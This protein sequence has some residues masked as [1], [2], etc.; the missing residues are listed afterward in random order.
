[1]NYARFMNYARLLPWFG[2]LICLLLIP[3]SDMHAQPILEHGA[4][5]RLQLSWHVNDGALAKLLPYEWTANIAADGAAKDVNLR[6]VLIERIAVTDRFNRPIGKSFSRQAYL[7]IPV[8]GPAGANGQMIIA[9]L[10][11]SQ[12]EADGN[13]KGF[14]VTDNFKVSQ[15]S[16][17]DGERQLR[18]EHW[19]LAAAS[20]ERIE[21]HIK[22]EAQFN[23]RTPATEVRFYDPKAPTT[24]Q[25][26]RVEQIIDQVR[27]GTLA[28]NRVSEISVNVAGGSFQSLFDGSEKLLSIDSIPWASHMISA[29]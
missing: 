2:I 22:F 23:P 9:G 10:T 26:H 13:F 14:K 19:S 6:L 28:I 17:H 29:P 4:E 16:E 8:S 24:Y 5:H 7:A 21:V 11:S 12:L 18:E 27:N 20:G 25:S 3:V 15:S 1:M